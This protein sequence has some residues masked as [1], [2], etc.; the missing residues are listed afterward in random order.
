M[1]K[2]LNIKRRKQNCQKLLGVNYININFTTNK[3]CI[4]HA[5]IKDVDIKKYI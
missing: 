5:M 4:R 2:A 3:Y 1:F